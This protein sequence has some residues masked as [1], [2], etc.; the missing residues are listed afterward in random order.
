MI[1]LLCLYHFLNNEIMLFAVHCE[2]KFFNLLWKNPTRKKSTINSII[3]L[4]LEYLKYNVLNN[5]AT[6]VFSKL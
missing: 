5:I 2:R 4:N 1:E 6:F 3:Q